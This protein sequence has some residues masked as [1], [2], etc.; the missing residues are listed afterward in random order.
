MVLDWRQYPT[1][2]QQSVYALSQ[3]LSTNNK[4]VDMAE[5]RPPKV[6]LTAG[7][8]M[9]MKF[10]FS[11]PREGDTQ[12]GHWWCWGVSKKNVPKLAEGDE[13][14]PY[15]LMLGKQHA[16]LADKLLKIPVQMGDEILLET[17][18]D[19]ESGLY[20]D[21]GLVENDKVIQTLSTKAKS[22]ESTTPEQPKKDDEL[23]NIVAK[24]VGAVVRGVCRAFGVDPDKITDPDG[25]LVMSPDMMRTINTCL[26]GLKKR[27]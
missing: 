26:I 24:E 2:I 11:K 13:Y 19:D 16:A 18:K 27:Q 5:E 15:S 20:W 14:E 7:S 9:V 10:G 12:Y 23:E 4:G 8:S 3:T 6:P 21:I 1:E 17:K 22:T 25:N